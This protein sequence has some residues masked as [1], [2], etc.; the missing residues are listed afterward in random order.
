MSTDASRRRDHLAGGPPGAEP[1]KD[2][3]WLG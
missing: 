3:A 1:Y 2:R